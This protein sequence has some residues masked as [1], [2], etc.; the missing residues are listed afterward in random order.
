MVDYKLMINFNIVLIIVL[1]NK[2]YF[3]FSFFID[4]IC[5]YLI[6]AITYGR[7]LLILVIPENKK[8]LVVTVKKTYQ[9]NTKKLTYDC[10]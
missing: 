7:P 3:F 6:C 2:R 4:I 9:K 5:I 1:P 10:H 8:F